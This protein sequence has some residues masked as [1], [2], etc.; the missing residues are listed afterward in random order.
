MT[1]EEREALP[2][3][4]A[5]SPAVSLDLSSLVETWRGKDHTAVLLKTD[6]LRVVFR[7]LRE[8]SQ[9]SAHKAAGDI[10]VQVLDGHI[11]CTAAGQI[12]ALRKGQ[13]FALRAAVP[14]AVRALRPAAILITLASGQRP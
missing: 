13:V 3:L 12:H 10:T 7:S 1:D 5:E 14:H 8:G 6:S 4:A 9:L 11:E 2:T